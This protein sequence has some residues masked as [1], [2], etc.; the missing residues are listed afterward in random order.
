MAIFDDAQFLNLLQDTWGIKEAAHIGVNIK[1]VE[2]LVAAF[3]FN[4]QKQSNAR[5]TEE[6][7]L[8][9]LF[10]QY[11]RSNNG[12]VTQDIVKG[13]MAKLDITANDMY[14]KALMEKV[15]I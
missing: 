6:F 10:R 13:M 11:D 3:R 12:E 8:R 5:H 7:V 2:H 14:L 4:I 1:D 9:E 15:C